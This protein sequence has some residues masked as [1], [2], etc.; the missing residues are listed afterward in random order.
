MTLDS[1]VISTLS[2]LL[3]GMVNA[4][5]SASSIDESMTQCVETKVLILYVHLQISSFELA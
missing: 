5:P 1:L 3:L 2:F 4:R